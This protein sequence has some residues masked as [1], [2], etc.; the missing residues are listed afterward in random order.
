MTGIDIFL[1]TRHLLL[2]TV[3]VE[4]FLLHLPA[5][6]QIVA[7]L[8]LASLVTAP[9]LVECAENG[10]WINTEG[11]LLRLDGLEQGSFFFLALL[12]LQLGLG[13]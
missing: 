1:R 7:K 13:S 3:F 10:L 8:A 11:Y 6:I 9:S 5:N 4:V 2:P 12:L